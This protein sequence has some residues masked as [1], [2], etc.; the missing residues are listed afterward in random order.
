[1][2]EYLRGENFAD[3]ELSEAVQSWV[4]A[5]KKRFFSIGH[6]QAC[7][8]MDQVCCEAA[9]ICRKIRHKNFYKYSCKKLL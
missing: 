4:K 3:D 9:R 8:Q 7:G 1:M 2:K 5:T 6:P